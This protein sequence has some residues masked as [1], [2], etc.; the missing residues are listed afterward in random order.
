MALLNDIK[1]LLSLPVYLG[2]QLEASSIEAIQKTASTFESQ[3]A[4]QTTGCALQARFL[5]NIAL[6]FEK[7]KKQ[8][9]KSTSS[10]SA[11]TSNIE[12]TDVERRSRSKVPSGVQSVIAMDQSSNNSPV[13]N[14]AEVPWNE[15]T[16]RSQ[17]S[18][19]TSTNADLRPK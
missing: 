11:T 15:I 17:Y 4:S 6:Q 12:L 8:T 1:L 14:C 2:K 13:E 18:F 5:S 10:Q 19:L 7:V 9:P 16:D 3:C